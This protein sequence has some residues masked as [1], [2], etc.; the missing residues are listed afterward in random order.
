LDE[1]EKDPNTLVRAKLKLDYL[2]TSLT[3]THITLKAA[4]YF[5]S[6]YQFFENL[7]K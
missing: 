6:L 4:T 5:P 2:K 3:A 1:K 7:L